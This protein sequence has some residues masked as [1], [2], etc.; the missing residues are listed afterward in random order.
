MFSEASRQKA[1]ENKIE[2]DKEMSDFMGKNDVR[3]KY[4]RLVSK[5]YRK[6]I[7]TSFF[8][9][10]KA[11][12]A[13]KAKCLDCVCFDIPEIKNCSV[14]TCPLHNIRPYQDKK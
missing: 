7:Y 1:V 9:T 10:T 14:S 8:S 2:S 6:C 5:K 13:I 3:A 4:L 12:N 11:K